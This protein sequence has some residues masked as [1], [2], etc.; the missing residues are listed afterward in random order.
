MKEELKFQRV[1]FLG[2]LICAIESF[3]FHWYLFY[4][5]RHMNGFN[6]EVVLDEIQ[7]QVRRNIF[8]PRFMKQVASL[9]R[10]H[11]NE[12]RTEDLQKS[13]RNERESVDRSGSIKSEP[14]TEPRSNCRG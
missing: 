11:V 1:R 7:E 8:C 6:A 10:F 3:F 12:H 4:F 13:V 5:Y 14:A 9:V 2:C